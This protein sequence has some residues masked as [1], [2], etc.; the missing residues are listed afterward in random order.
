VIFDI[1][2]DENDLKEISEEQGIEILQ[3]MDS[4]D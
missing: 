1:K 3:I 4:D 2:I